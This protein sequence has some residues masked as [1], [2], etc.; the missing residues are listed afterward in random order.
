[1]AE[2]VLAYPPR[3]A[4][5]SSFGVGS[6]ECSRSDVGIGVIVFLGNGDIRRSEIALLVDVFR[7]H[8]K[9]TIKARSG[10]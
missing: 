2:A 9:L 3:F 5:S 6:R 10:G 1:M 7:S 8:R 4:R